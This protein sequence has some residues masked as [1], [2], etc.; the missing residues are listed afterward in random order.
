MRRSPSPVYHQARHGKKLQ[1]WEFVSDKR[2]LILGDSNINPIA[3]IQNTEVQADSYPGASFYHFHKLM[4]QTKTHSH[5]D[6]LIP[7][8]GINNRDQDA[9][10]NLNQAAPFHV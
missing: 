6:V 1:D 8:V 2:I 7:S 9:A 3:L 10:K 5:T 4:D